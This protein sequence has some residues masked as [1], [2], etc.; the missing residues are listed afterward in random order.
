MK[1]QEKKQWKEDLMEVLIEDE[2]NKGRKCRRSAGRIY[3]HLSQWKTISNKGKG[4]KIKNKQ[5]YILFSSY[6]YLCIDHFLS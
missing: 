6:P 4:K 5:I 3:C 2:M 1:T